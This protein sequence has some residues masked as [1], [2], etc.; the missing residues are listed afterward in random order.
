M[1][2]FRRRLLMAKMSTSQELWD[3]SW[4]FGYGMPEDYGFIPDPKSYGISL[5]SDGLQL[6]ATG[7]EY[8]GYEMPVTK[9]EVG[10]MECEVRFVTT[11]FGNG[12]RMLVVDGVSGAHAS[13]RKYGNTLGLYNG[14][15]EGQLISKYPED[16]LFHTV[17]VRRNGDGTSS[18][19][20]D[21]L[22]VGTVDDNSLFTGRS[23]MLSQGCTSVIRTLKFKVGD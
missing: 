6:E 23:W 22:L 13:I 4:E 17:K 1:S 18:F 8:S 15:G 21:K 20:I 10:S 5:V 11:A 14:T 3:Y 12:F 9:V 7:G 2:L 16:G 19:W